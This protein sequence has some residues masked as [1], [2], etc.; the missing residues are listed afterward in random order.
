ME[1][2]RQYLGIPSPVHLICE[3][4]R[5]CSVYDGESVYKQSHVQLILLFK[6]HTNL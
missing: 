3:H 4:E 6:V 1:T 5:I 2:K